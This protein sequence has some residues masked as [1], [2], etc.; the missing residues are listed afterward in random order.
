MRLCVLCIPVEWGGK[1]GTEATNI[2]EME[3]GGAGD[4]VYV[5]GDFPTRLIC[6]RQVVL[7]MKYM[8]VDVVPPYVPYALGE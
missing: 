6:L 5:S 7:H 8:Y 4:I 1:G 3:M 2:A